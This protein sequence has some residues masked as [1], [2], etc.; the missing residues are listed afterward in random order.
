MPKCDGPCGKEFSW[1]D[2]GITTA[3]QNLCRDCYGFWDAAQQEAI[4]C[5]RSTVV[6]RLNAALRGAG[7]M[8]EVMD[9]RKLR[10]KGKFKR[11]GQKDLPLV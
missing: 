2:G 4:Q 7:V 10:T 3:T 9:T 1:A 11:T 8:L 5:Y 6:A